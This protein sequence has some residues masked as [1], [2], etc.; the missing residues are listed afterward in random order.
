MPGHETEIIDLT[1]IVGD[2][3]IPC[4]YDRLFG[5][6]PRPAAWVMVAQC[7]CGTRG[8]RLVCEG[9]KDAT[10]ATERAL[11]CPSDCGLV[12]SPARHAFT[13]IEPLDR[14]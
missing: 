7:E 10:L 3:E 1:E 6:G 14:A 4:D 9:C 5:C 11:A 2:L 13:R 12:Y 8:E